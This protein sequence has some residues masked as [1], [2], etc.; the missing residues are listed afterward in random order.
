[1]AVAASDRWRLRSQAE[2][3]V[4]S[5]PVVNAGKS[6]SSMQLV[7][8]APQEAGRATTVEGAAKARLTSCTGAARPCG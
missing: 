1:M 6:D 5:I 4:H 3:P 8:S 7:G 2:N